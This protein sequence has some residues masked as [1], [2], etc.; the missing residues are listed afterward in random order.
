MNSTLEQ[1][2]EIAK[3]HPSASREVLMIPIEAI[4][5]DPEQPRKEPRDLD[6]LAASIEAIGVQQPLLVRPNPNQEDA[7]ILVAGE[8]RLLAASRAGK[9]N[10]PCMVLADLDDPGQRLVVQLTENI[11]R[12]DLDM[13]EIARTIQ[14]LIDELQMPKGDVA[15]L[16]GKGQSFV[17]KHLALLKATGP[18]KEALDRGL[19]QS[20][21]TFRLFRKLPEDRQK[22]L[23]GRKGTRALPIARAEVE[24][25]AAVETPGRSLG[26]LE[27]A[28]QFSLRLT[29]QQLM[30][31]IEALGGQPPAEP[32]EL[33]ATLISLL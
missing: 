31:I 23:L 1:L 8:R 30:H 14:T 9:S 24:K 4:Q 33:K 19:L 21:E 16:L 20:P 10:V 3:T 25:A 6:E 28:Q 26:P 22:K 15:R 27:G 18:S 32:G 17:S 12:E 11:Q 2:A 13:M 5:P 29:S 7:Y